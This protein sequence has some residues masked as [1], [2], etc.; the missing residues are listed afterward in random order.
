[1]MDGLWCWLEGFA[2]KG[3]W[4]IMVGVG[5]GRV[6]VRCRDMKW[7]WSLGVCGIGGGGN[8]KSMVGLDPWLYGP[9]KGWGDGLEL[10]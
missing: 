3:L 6:V 4:W 7:Y 5:Y 2:E 9:D 1:M 10:R 8:M